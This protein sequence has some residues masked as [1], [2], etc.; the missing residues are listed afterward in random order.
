[1]AKDSSP[2]ALVDGGRAP[3]DGDL[4]KWSDAKGGWIPTSLD[5]EIA[6]ATKIGIYTL[7]TVDGSDGDVLTTNGSGVLSWTTP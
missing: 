7:P 1:M 3:Q 2:K 6:G 4:L 5:T